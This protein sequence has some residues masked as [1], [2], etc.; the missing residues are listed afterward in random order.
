MTVEEPHMSPSKTRIQLMESESKVHNLHLEVS[1]LKDHI[2]MLK[3]DNEDCQVE[4]KRFQEKENIWK[5]EMVLYKASC[6][7]TQSNAEADL[8]NRI[9]S[10]EEELKKQRERCL[11]I[12]E[13]KEDEVNMLKSN[14]ESTLEAAFRAA[15]K[16]AANSALTRGPSTSNEESI[17]SAEVSPSLQIDNSHK[18]LSASIIESA[19]SNASSSAHNKEL[20]NRNRLHRAKSVSIGRDQVSLEL[21][22][23]VVVLGFLM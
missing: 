22:K 10:L 2:R 6:K 23:G 15:A 17:Y 18:I 16:T 21:G 14:M 5:Q 7:E 11:T 1:N 9:L 8:K 4:I 12:V 19:V 3:K 13:E 20:S